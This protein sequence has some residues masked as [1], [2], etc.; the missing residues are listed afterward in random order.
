MEFIGTSIGSI[1]DLWKDGSGIDVPVLVATGEHV[2]SARSYVRVACQIA[3]TAID[4]A[5]DTSARF[6]GR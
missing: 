6:A 1:P 3:G 2:K 4:I 5:T